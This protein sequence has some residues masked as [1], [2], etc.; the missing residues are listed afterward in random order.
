MRKFFYLR[1]ALSNIRRNRKFYFPYLL[2]CTFTIAMFYIVCAI[3]V[4]HTLDSVKGAATLKSYTI[5]GAFVVAIFATIFLFYTN[6]FLTKR[7]RHEF[8]LYNILGME[9]RHIARMMLDESLFIA[10]VTMAAGIALGLGLSKL[11]AL[12]AIKL[13]RGQA[14]FGMEFVPAAAKATLIVFAIIYALSYFVELRRMSRSSAIDLL[15]S[16]SQGE[17]EPKTRW[18]MALIGVLCLGGGYWISI[19]TQNVLQAFTLFF[20]AV[21][22]VIIGTYL[23]FIA[24]SIAVL[25]MLRANRRYYYKPNHFISVSGMIYRMKQNASGLATICILST[26]VL[27]MA[28]S[29]VSLAIG[30]E[31]TI[32]KV[33][34]HEIQFEDRGLIEDTDARGREVI[35][36]ALAR[37][38]VEPEN[39]VSFRTISFTA[40]R[41][42]NTFVFDDSNFDYY[43]G[44]MA[45]IAVLPYEDYLAL[46]PDSE[47]PMPGADEVLVYGSVPDGE[48][49]NLDGL[50]MRIAGR[51][52]SFPYLST[53]V[54]FTEPVVFVVRDMQVVERIDAMQEE[55]YGN[56]ASELARVFAFDI[57]LSDAELAAAGDDVIAA[58]R[59]AYDHSYTTARYT[60]RQSYY[61]MNGGLMFLGIFLGLLFVMAMVLMMYYR[62]I[63]EGYDDRTRYAIMRNVGLDDREIRRSINS[64]VLTVFFLPLIVACIHTGMA[65]FIVQR[66]MLVFGLTDV[67]LLLICTGATMLFFSIFYVITYL[68]TA[69]VYYRIVSGASTH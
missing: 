35:E 34:S 43:E 47:L 6:S 61:A 31:D 67:S 48:T 62:Q 30:T 44:T 55:A 10:L 5:V 63:S 1:L 27:V 39:Y 22:L 66:V 40:G 29:T 7:R 16:A 51:I 19:S 18:L 3:S 37:H 8:G 53:G 50:S 17:R 11:V 56:A 21:T 4:G 9:R 23:L 26:M 58:L 52:D 33:Y 24:G 2:A 65:F 69:N 45:A 15:K 12:V 59:D 64:Q 54:M 32:A 46:A 14:E 41:E 68:V 25:K 36:T 28:S 13:V 42:G 60:G 20:L 38:G 57:P 49:V